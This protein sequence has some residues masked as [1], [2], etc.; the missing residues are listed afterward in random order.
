MGGQLTQDLLGLLRL[1]ACV[2]DA[3]QHKRAVR[4]EVF[5]RKLLAYGHPLG[6]VLLGSLQIIL[7]QGECAEAKERLP[8]ANQGPITVHRRIL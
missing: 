3:R 5:I 4:Q 6:H 1:P 8:P 7:L 2:F